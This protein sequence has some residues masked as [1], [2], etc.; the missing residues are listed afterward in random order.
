MAHATSAAGEGHSRHNEEIDA[1]ACSK[2]ISV[3]ES[4]RNSL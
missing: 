4:Q 2:G 3:N 1:V